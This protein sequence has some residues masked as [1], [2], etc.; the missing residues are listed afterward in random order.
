MLCITSISPKHH[1][2]EIQFKAIKSWI[3]SGFTVVSMNGPEEVDF[4]KPFY[5]DVTFVKTFR[6]FEK[7]Y[8]RPLVSI[9]ALM[10]YAK[11]QSD[12]HICLVNSDIELFLSSTQIESIEEKMSEMILISNRLDY[13]D[14]YTG[15]KY[16]AGF[17]VFFIHKKWLPFFPQSMH[18]MG[19]TFWDYWVPYT[20][21]KAFINVHIINDLI[22]FHKKHPFQYHQDHW[23]KS[24]RFFLWEAMLYQFSDT[25]EIGKMSDFVFKYIYKACKSL[26]LNQTTT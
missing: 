7:T 11:E 15:V 5:P 19:M 2:N 18:C 8:G 1:N 6:T 20:A 9:N 17:D 3:E 13:D 22:A 10:D 16:K 12:P 21:T 4:L 24:G 25:N 23:L 26:N 14:N